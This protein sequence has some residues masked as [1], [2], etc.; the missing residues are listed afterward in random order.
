M[1]RRASSRCTSRV[2]GYVGRGVPITYIFRPVKRQVVVS[3]G[4]T[5][6]G[7]LSFPFHFKLIFVRIKRLPWSAS[8]QNGGLHTSRQC[9]NSETARALFLA[10]LHTVTAF[11]PRGFPR[12]TFWDSMCCRDGVLAATGT[13][14][15]AQTPDSPFTTRRSWHEC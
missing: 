2:H 6:L 4:R 14:R 15:T 1:C 9:D 5:V 7:H 10:G 3:W 12:C 11:S 13:R 8:K